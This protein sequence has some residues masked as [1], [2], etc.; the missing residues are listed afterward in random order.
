V[1]LSKFLMRLQDTGFISLPQ[2]RLR[3]CHAHLG[4]VFSDLSQNA[5]VQT[6]KTSHKAAQKTTN[7]RE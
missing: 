5:H 7:E 3:L 6:Q 4:C 1:H 2:P